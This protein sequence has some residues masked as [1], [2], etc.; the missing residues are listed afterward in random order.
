MVSISW[1]LQEFSQPK[2]MRFFITSGRQ[3]TTF[4][5]FLCAIWNFELRL[6]LAVITEP[7]HKVSQL[8]PYKVEIHYS[9]FA[10]SVFPQFLAAQNNINM[11]NSA[12]LSVKI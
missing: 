1:L 12:L 8:I 7:R 4:S 3:T 6:K 9:C 2:P 11:Q 5:V 10:F